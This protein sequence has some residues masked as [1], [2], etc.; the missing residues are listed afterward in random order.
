MTDISCSRVR[1]YTQMCQF[2]CLLIFY[3][4][5]FLYSMSIIPYI[6]C[7][8]VCAR[9]SLPIYLSLCVFVCLCVCHQIIVMSVYT[10]VKMRALPTSTEKDIPAPLLFSPLAIISKVCS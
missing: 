1:V 4:F 9:L 5:A 2:D 7:A 3:I 10:M 6:I 8:C